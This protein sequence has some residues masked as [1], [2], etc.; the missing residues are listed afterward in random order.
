MSYLVALA[1]LWFAYRRLLT[2]LHIYQQEEYDSRR[3]IHWLFARYSFD[4]KLSFVIFV[5]GTLELAIVLADWLTDVLV[6]AAFLIFWWVEKSRRVRSKKPLV[7]TGRAKR[8]LWTALAVLALM[9]LVIAKWFPHP[10][11]WLVAVQAVP[12]ALT[13]GNLLTEPY[14]RRLQKRFWNEAH[15]KLLSLK[16]FTIGITGSYGKTSS[17]HLL[18][19]VL[20]IQAP[21][22]IT[23]GSVN[24]P[25]GIA[26]VVR[27]QLGPH[28]RFFICEMGA[29]GPGSIARLCRL[30]PPDLAVITAI[31]M[32]HYER[33][34]T[35][36]VV[37]H[38][39]FELAE[40]AAKKGGPVVVAEQALEFADARNFR[41]RY[42]NTIVVGRGADCALRILEPSQTSTGIQARVAWRGN[43]YTL[44]APIFGEHHIGN[45]CVVFATACT[46]GVAPEDVILALASV[47][48][49]SHRLEVKQGAGGWK[50]IDDAYNSNPV[51]FAAALRL[52]NMLRRDEG[53]RVLV[54]P[55]MV[56]MGKAHETEHRKIGELAGSMVDVLLPVLPE[57]IKALT[58]AYSAA[59]PNGIIIPCPTFVTAQSW[60]N[61]HLTANDIVLLENDLPDLYEARLRL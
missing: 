18:G 10:I 12:F 23:P 59:N 51:G 26:R 58:L 7:M 35:L 29:Y 3:F 25:M 61:S 46:L 30:A 40:A 22:L 60:M 55:G 6:V 41:D 21:T 28:H 53:R 24:T 8:I 19:H 32:A 13:V 45:M 14:E 9:A 56:E 1:F 4:T 49:I 42:A 43:E 2:Y 50:L 54:T 15:T 36:D 47:P 52:L 34:K 33:F 57:R 27:E 44:R 17:K 20:E 37:A 11:F 39:K 31:G 48:Q 38:T 16:P 5:V